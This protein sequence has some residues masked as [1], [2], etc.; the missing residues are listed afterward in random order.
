[1]DRE[2]TIGERMDRVERG[3]RRLALSTLA[4]FAL[5][6]TG[7]GAAWYWGGRIDPSGD[8][9][10]AQGSAAKV[11]LR[12]IGKALPR[13]APS[14]ALRVAREVV[15]EAAEDGDGARFLGPKLTRIADV[16][17]VSEDF[18]ADAVI[19]AMKRAS[20]AG[21]PVAP[22]HLL[23]A[24]DEVYRASKKGFPENI[25]STLDIYLLFHA[26]GRSHADII[27]FMIDAM[28]K[29]Q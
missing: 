20:K 1:M 26:E 21:K 24:V 29:P 16:H 18:V 11:P 4:G 6:A 10:A 12:P 8:E 9:R 2:R 7:I 5:A 15:P 13:H 14:A 19:D 22:G 3:L 27:R 17:G 28:T 25:K 23:D